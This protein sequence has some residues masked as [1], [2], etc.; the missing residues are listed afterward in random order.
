MR[1]LAPIV[2]V[3]CVSA[4]GSSSSSS[5]TPPNDTGTDAPADVAPIT[6]L[7]VQVWQRVGAGVPEVN[8]AA[9]RQDGTVIGSMVTGADGVGT[10][11]DLSLG[12]E[13]VYL[14]AWK[15]GTWSVEIE[16]LDQ[17]SVTR[18]RKEYEIAADVPFPIWLFPR[19]GVSLP[20]ISGAIKGT[21]AGRL[22]SMTS[23]VGGTFYNGPDDSYSIR[24]VPGKKGAF[25][26]LE[27]DSMPWTGRTLAQNLVQ[28][29]QFDHPA[30]TS[31]TVLDLDFAA[32]TKLTPKTLKFS[33]QIP[34]GAS[35][36]F[37][38]E[39]LGLAN[40]YVGDLDGLSLAG[41][42]ATS[43]PSS[44]GTSIDGTMQYVEPTVTGT[45]ITVGRLI[46]SGATGGVSERYL[47]GAP[48][49]GDVIKDFDPPMPV[50]TAKRT[51]ADPLS[52]DGA[53]A[54]SDVLLVYSKGNGETVFRFY[55]PNE[56]LKSVT[57][58]P[59]LPADALA[60]LPPSMPVRFATLREWFRRGTAAHYQATSGPFPLTK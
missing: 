46:P 58:L 55:V 53:A 39:S 28:W 45:P 50:P 21:G 9:V 3:A 30:V 19:S 31:D 1:L 27:V 33:L 25:V 44:D 6:G 60:Q 42:A 4:C 43:A 10:I 14:V 54:G 34:G 16:A 15:D 59:T 2:V 11:P 12:S 26:V 24:V 18:G 20:K 35:G 5:T 48:K 22:V 36:P 17:A 13:P 49:D 57:K 32:A 51:L 40:A 52:F 29:G 47:D 7:K 56:L 8:V 41:V 37:G 38:A 23:S